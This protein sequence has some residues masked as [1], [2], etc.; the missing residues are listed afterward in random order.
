MCEH[1]C[2]CDYAEASTNVLIMQY[3][4]LKYHNIIILY[5]YIRLRERLGS[6][7]VTLA[8]ACTHSFM[9]HGFRPTNLGA[10]L[11][12]GDDKDRPHMGFRPAKLRPGVG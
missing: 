11:L 2:A 12:D 5:H 10:S 4:I 3:I 9:S 1:T 7:L 6:V 8:N